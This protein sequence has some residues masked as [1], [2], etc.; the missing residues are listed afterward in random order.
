MH[1]EPDAG[2]EP[3]QE[4]A[5]WGVTQSTTEGGKPSNHRIVRK[6]RYVGLQSQSKNKTILMS[7]KGRRFW[8]LRRDLRLRRE[9]RSGI[10]NFV[11]CV[12]VSEVLVHPRDCLYFCHTQL[13]SPPNLGDHRSSWSL[14]SISVMSILDLPHAPPRN[15]T[16]DLLGFRWHFSVYRICHANLKNWEINRGFGTGNLR[17]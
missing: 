8:I 13:F 4:A 12:T 2:Q 6:D 15:S 14:S 9:C 11:N 17:D 1:R 10:A 16:N 3:K 7:T 5:E